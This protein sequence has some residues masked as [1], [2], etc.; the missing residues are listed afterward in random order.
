M[1]PTAGPGVLPERLSGGGSSAAG[2]ITL[3]WTHLPFPQG[4]QSL[5][6][7]WGNRVRLE[8]VERHLRLPSLRPLGL[9]AADLAAVQ[10]TRT[11]GALGR[12]RQI[13][14]RVGHQDHLLLQGALVRRR[15]VLLDEGVLFFLGITLR[16]VP[17]IVAA[18]ALVL[19][20]R[21]LLLRRGHCHVECVDHPDALRFHR[22]ARGHADHGRGPVTAGVVPSICVETL[23]TAM[24]DEARLNVSA[25]AVRVREDAST[26]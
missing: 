10:L 11:G 20:L 15:R 25:S 22:R 9:A 17:L 16:V 23:K 18:A 5:H 14:H 24:F 4:V 7:D 13:A 8:V 6:P 19:R 12:Q 26:V 3:A 21:L 2:R 1:P